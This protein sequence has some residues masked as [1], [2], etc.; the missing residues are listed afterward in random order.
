MIIS[1]YKRS[2]NKTP[3]LLKRALNS[4]FN[5]S[6]KDFKVFVIGDCYDDLE[7]LFSVTSLYSPEKLHC[8]NLNKSVERDKYGDKK[9]RKI[10]WSC[11]GLTA[12]NFGIEKAMEFGFEYVAHL[13]HDDHWEYNHLEFIND[14]IEQ[15]KADWVCTKSTYGGGLVYPLVDLTRMFIS[16]LPLPGGIIKSSVCYNF[17]SIPLVFR[18]MYELIGESIP[19][20]ADL[21]ERMNNYIREKHLASILVNKVTCYH[22]SEGFTLYE[23]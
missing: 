14:A 19:S 18:N 22:E 8:F 16:F 1:T 5:Q 4:V 10:L 11:G 15:K 13:D 3:L 6:Y 20:D 17:K 21:W 12:I 23:H 7:E 9:D 2:D